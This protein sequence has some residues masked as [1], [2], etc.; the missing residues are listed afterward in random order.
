MWIYACQRTTPYENWVFLKTL[1]SQMAGWAKC[2]YSGKVLQWHQAQ[3][4]YKAIYVSRKKEAKH[5]HMLL[6]QVLKKGGGGE[7]HD[8]ISS[9]ELK[10]DVHYLLW[11]IYFSKNCRTFH[12]FKILSVF[13]FS[14]LNAIYNT[15]IHSK[16]I[17]NQSRRNITL[18]STKIRHTVT[19]KFA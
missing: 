11:W 15:T 5:K 7:G 16:I 12:I 18:T 1:T 2:N 14:L 10:C 9:A 19:Q 13:V 17:F 6:C 4:M 3:W 8:L